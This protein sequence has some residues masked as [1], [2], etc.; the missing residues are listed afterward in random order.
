MPNV[1]HNV[2]INKMTSRYMSAMTTFS[3]DIHMPIK[4]NVDKMAYDLSEGKA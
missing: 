1:C 2:D 4:L 3:V